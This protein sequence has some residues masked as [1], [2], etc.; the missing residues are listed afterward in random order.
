MTNRPRWLEICQEN[1]IPLLEHT[2]ASLLERKTLDVH[3]R[4]AAL[5]ASYHLHQCVLS[6]V[7][8]NEK[9]RH[10]V[11]MALLRQCVEALTIVEVGLQPQEFA[12]DLLRSWIEDLLTHGQIRKKLEAERW[13]HYGHGLWQESWA[14]YFGNL[15]RA[16]QP[17]AH[18]SRALMGWQFSMPATSPT[19]K[20]DEGTIV[21][22]HI[23]SNTK[24]LLKGARV[25]LFVTL[26][27]WTVAR[28]LEEN[29]VLCPMRGEK[30]KKWGESIGASDILDSATSAWADVFL[31][32]LLFNDQGFRL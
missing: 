11:A 23:G 10:S 30:L 17:Y 21:Y 32:H 16:V 19:P 13:P 25:S 15:A 4:T 28:L 2:S 1:I 18:Y 6:S 14:E 22:A 20:P 7:D 26:V 24:D 5:L 3:V 8:A 31:P 29:M 9:G 27:G 12:T